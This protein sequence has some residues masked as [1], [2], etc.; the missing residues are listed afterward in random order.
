M[1]R[2]WSKV[3]KSPDCWIWKAA[4]R[5]GYGVLTITTQRQKRVIYAHRL[6]YELAN[7]PIP[8][9]MYVLH[10]CDRAACVR[11]DHLF[12]GS[13]RDNLADMTNK[14]RRVQVFG[15]AQA[16]AKLTWRKVSEIRG[17]Y[18]TRHV[19]HRKL[20]ALFHVDYG[21]IGRIIRGERW[22]PVSVKRGVGP[23]C[24]HKRGS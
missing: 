1:E 13:Q 6:S 10:H 3:E 4:K 16:N 5:N 9:G 2:F 22:N 12:L 23:V 8:K 14:G 19:S 20:A 24:Y 18:A 21:T 7:G 15:E 17:L 11:P